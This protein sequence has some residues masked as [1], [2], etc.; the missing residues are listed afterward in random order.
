MDASFIL[1]PSSFLVF[2]IVFAAIFTQTVTGFGLALVSMPLLALVLP[3]QVAAPLVALFG[4]VAELLL[5]LRYRT[6]L[7][8]RAVAVLIGA[9]VV[10]IP[11]GVY[12]LGEMDEGGGNGRSRCHR[13][14]LCFICLVRAAAAGALRPLVGLVIWLCRRHFGRGL[15]YQ[16][17]TGDHLRQL[18]PLAAS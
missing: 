4:L 5:L 14:G 2:L 9:S 6:A 12:V 11:V 16:R 8:V 17:P 15:Q 13:S 18:P 3:I 1:H 10:G 7:N